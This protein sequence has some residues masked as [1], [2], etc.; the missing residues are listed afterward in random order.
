M[1]DELLLLL[2][3]HSRSLMT[4][5][6]LSLFQTKTHSNCNKSYDIDHKVKV[7]IILFTNFVIT[8][9]DLRK[10]TSDGV[11]PSLEVGSGRKTLAFFGCGLMCDPT[12]RGLSKYI[13]K[14]LINIRAV[15]NT[16]SE[17]IVIILNAYNTMR[18]QCYD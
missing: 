11:G 2:K 9:S 8:I 3:G 10:K 12:R 7:N 5:K 6:A 18:K 13:I 14:C 4:Y 17:L 15:I 16:V 1:I